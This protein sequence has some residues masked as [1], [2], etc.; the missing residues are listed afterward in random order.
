MNE[1]VFSEAVP[2][3]PLHV[4]ALVARYGFD[5]N[6]QD[7]TGNE[8]HAAAYG[9]PVYGSGSIGQS[10]F[11]DG[12][13]DYVALPFGLP[14]FEDMTFACWV[15]WDGTGGDWQRIFDFGNDT[16]ENLFLT[17]RSGAGTLRFGI[18][19]GGDEQMTETSVL[20]SGTWVHVAVTLHDQTAT[21]Y[22]NGTLAVSNNAT[23]IDPADFK[24]S[25]NYI[26]K[27]QW[28][29]PL[30]NGRIDE[31]YLCNYALSDSAIV[32]LMNNRYPPSMGPAPL[33]LSVTNGLVHLVWPEEFIGWRLQQQ[34]VLSETNWTDITGVAT[35]SAV[36]LP[37]GT[38][39]SRFFRMVYP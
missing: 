32:N 35:A 27:S 7:D 24:P 22:V 10:I 6:T 3:E 34:D 23:T 1:S 17:P 36:Q 16:S 18:R 25:R 33:S 29:D 21:L 5:G 2:A 15:N 12:V 9:A 37:V 19:N 28:P 4:P 26:G 14:E 31:V 39:S 8:N 11:L 30:F 20:P 13:D 38:N